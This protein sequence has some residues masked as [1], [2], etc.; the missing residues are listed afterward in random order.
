MIFLFLFETKHIHAKHGVCV[1]GI[2]II[3]NPNSQVEVCKS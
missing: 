3:E 2:Q 1:G